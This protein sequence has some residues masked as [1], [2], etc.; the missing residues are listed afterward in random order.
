MLSKVD[1]FAPEDAEKLRDVVA[2]IEQQAGSSA[3]Q[4]Q[5]AMAGTEMADPEG[6][7][8]VRQQNHIVRQVFGMIGLKHF[9]EARNGAENRRSEHRL[10]GSYLDR[11]RRNY[12]GH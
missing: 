4:V 1:D 12:R 7:E 3:S 5:N 6:G 10:A 8:G 11:L 2:Q 9:P